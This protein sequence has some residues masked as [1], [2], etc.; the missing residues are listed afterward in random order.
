MRKE[1]DVCIDNGALY[2]SGI[3]LFLG[4]REPTAAH[5]TA[6]ALLLRGSKQGAHIT[7]FS[8]LICVLSLSLI[9][10]IKSK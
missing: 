7:A 3:S 2:Y 4:E 10:I 8:V 9:I 5:I 6:L 1:R